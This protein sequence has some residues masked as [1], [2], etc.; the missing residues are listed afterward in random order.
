MTSFPL[1]YIL[2][3]ELTDFQKH[4]VDKWLTDD[5]ASP[6]T[7]PK[8]THDEMFKVYGNKH[9]DKIIL[10]YHGIVGDDNTTHFNSAIAKHL[11]E[12]GGWTIHDYRQGI[13][14]RKL[15]T[16]K[17][18]IK[19]E[20]KKI[21]AIL[22]ETGGNDKTG[23]FTKYETKPNEDGILVRHAT[24]EEKPLLK[25]FNE[26]TTRHG[27]KNEASNNL[28]IVISRHPYDVAGMSSGRSWRSCMR[29]PADD[30]AQKEGD[31]GINHSYI[32][33]DLRHQTMVAYLTKA[34]DNSIEK[35]I[36]RVAIKRFTNDKDHDIWRPESSIY[37]TTSNGFLNR[38][39]EV[40]SNH[41]PSHKGGYFKNPDLYNDSGSFYDGGDDDNTEGT[42]K[43][44]L[45]DYGHQTQHVSKY[46][47]NNSNKLHSDNDDPSLEVIEPHGQHKLRTRYWHN[48]GVLHREEGKPA[49]EAHIISNNGQELP[50]KKAHLNNGLYHDPKDGSPAHT[51][52][53]YD[54]DTLIPNHHLERHYRF[55]KLHNSIIDGHS[56][57]EIEPDG[58]RLKS[59]F[60]GEEH[61]DSLPAH[62]QVKFFPNS[63]I[64]RS[65]TIVHSRYGKAISNK[66]TT[67][68]QDGN[69][70][71]FEL[72][73]KRGNGR[74]SH[75]WRK[76]GYM[77][78]H[79]VNGLGVFE[80]TV[81]GHPASGEYRPVIMHVKYSNET[82]TEDPSHDKII[83]K[84]F[85]RGTSLVAS[86][87]GGPSE[88]TNLPNRKT[89]KYYNNDSE[90]HREDGPALLDKEY[91]E[92]GKLNHVEMYHRKNGITP[93]D[94]PVGTVIKSD[95]YSHRADADTHSNH[96]SITIMDRPHPNGS[97]ALTRRI[98]YV[99]DY[100]ERPEDISQNNI[101][102]VSYYNGH[103][104]ERNGPNGEPHK[105]H[106]KGYLFYSN[107]GSSE[108]KSPDGI[109]PGYVSVYGN[110][111]YPTDSSHLVNYTH[112]EIGDAPLSGGRHADI[113]ARMS[114]LDAT[115]RHPNGSKL[116]LYRRRQSNGMSAILSS[117]NYDHKVKYEREA[118]EDKGKFSLID[119]DHVP[120]KVANH[121]EIINGIL[122]DHGLKRNDVKN[123]HPYNYLKEVK[124]PEL[125]N[126]ALRTSEKDPND[127]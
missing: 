23:T 90:L 26:D 33:H 62:H 95:W 56:I 6:K 64:K 3:E 79:D 75:N 30:Q 106:D 24:T 121:N 112:F 119:K 50:Y 113:E 11:H 98:G 18:F 58:M 60:Y 116:M 37:G 114:G 63:N 107:T 31:H 35:P 34:G 14:T 71:R 94:V 4:M 92:N 38:V 59:H 47:T 78:G 10:P 55:G 88:Y 76:D 123:L 20:F 61:S 100:A 42:L 1:T 53:D 111:K 66:E 77:G 65:E 91:D 25:G 127:E 40:M 104:Y 7:L 96:N 117:P 57:R 86:D 49:L 41:Y 115:V 89:V 120:V 22:Q 125:N 36:A 83:S 103:G 97:K 12:N 102:S 29:L 43:T 109:H 5:K 72:E 73:E 69:T 99:G 32:R 28:Q 48:N 27:G 81:D 126:F 101:R 45:S 19:P 39:N 84:T 17:G 87:D 67:Y 8:D 110:D 105:L 82:P 52:I 21:G 74:I 16:K 68:N 108:T 93:H 44:L 124:L 85:R 15:V 13:A 80:K 9:A 118:F 46:K 2:N 51:F 122:K 70:T 54:L